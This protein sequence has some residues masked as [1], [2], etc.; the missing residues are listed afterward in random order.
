LEAR[1]E[2]GWEGGEGGRRSSPIENWKGIVQDKLGKKKRG[3]SRKNGEEKG[4][5]K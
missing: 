5:T 1:G 2:E 4:V 3:G